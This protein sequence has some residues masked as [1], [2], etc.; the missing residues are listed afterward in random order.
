M[1]TKHYILLSF[2]LAI[3]LS[4][5]F[6]PAQGAE[7]TETLQNTWIDGEKDDHFTLSNS[8][9]TDKVYF[10]Y[11]MQRYAFFIESNESINSIQI[12]GTAIPFDNSTEGIVT[13]I[14]GN[15]IEIVVDRGILGENCYFTVKIN[16]KA[17]ISIDPFGIIPTLSPQPESESAEPK[18]IE[19]D[20]VSAFKNIFTTPWFYLIFCYLVIIITEYKRHPIVKVSNKDGKV[21]KL[22]KYLFETSENELNK[23][24]MLFMSSDGVREIYCTNTLGALETYFWQE[25][26]VIQHDYP[27]L[28][29]DKLKVPSTIEMTKK[30]ILIKPKNIFL[31]IFFTL[32]RVTPFRGATM[33]I[34]NALDCTEEVIHEVDYLIPYFS[35][36][37]IQY[38]FDM[39]YEEEEFDKVANKNKW[40]KKEG[41]D[42]LYSDLLSLQKGNIRNVKTFNIRSED[43]VYKNLKEALEDKQ[44]RFE[45]INSYENRMTGLEISN[46]NLEKRLQSAYDTVQKQKLDT[47][48]KIREGLRPMEENNEFL[49]NNFPDMLA[50][51]LKFRS[52]SFTEKDAIQKAIVKHIDIADK[53][54]VVLREENIKLKAMLEIYSKN[55]TKT[56]NPNEITIKGEKKDE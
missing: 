26:L 18:G 20:L 28:L 29:L 2:F 9:E 31:W 51:T 42:L 11:S 3:T 22:G 35:M 25:I 6:M 53:E 15:N 36:D 1:K 55:I 48:K 52:L 45:I 16:E 14:I 8:S 56:F 40:I 5:V 24:K 4:S 50:T 54:K 21:E 19:L 7:Y 49:R 46:I 47:D 12:N 39:S 41:V 27:F 43:I 37:A 38:K 34:Y 32:F 17:P 10:A 23:S 44:S 33:R 30:T 13:G